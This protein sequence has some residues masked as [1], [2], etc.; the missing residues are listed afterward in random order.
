[1]SENVQLQYDLS[2]AGLVPD[3][4]ATTYVDKRLQLVVD[5]RQVETWEITALQSHMVE[6]WQ[7]IFARYLCRGEVPVSPGLPNT[8]LDEATAEELETIK[9]SEAYRLV[10]RFKMPSLKAAVQ[11]FTDQ[12]TAGF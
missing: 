8:P 1:M 12:A 9:K 7:L 6:Q 2:D 11:S 5:G 10:K 3:N 4:G